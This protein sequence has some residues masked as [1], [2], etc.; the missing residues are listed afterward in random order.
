MLLSITLNDDTNDDKPE[1]Y[2]H[3]LPHRQNLL[4]KFIGFER[5]GAH[6]CDGTWRTQNM[7]PDVHEAQIHQN[8]S[9]PVPSIAA[10]SK[11]R[12]SNFC[13][14][15]DI[16][17]TSLRW[18]SRASEPLQPGGERSVRSRGSVHV[19]KERGRSKPLQV[20]DHQLL[21]AGV[22][23]LDGLAKLLQTLQGR[24][25]SASSLQQEEESEQLLLTFTVSWFMRR[26]CSSGLE[27][28]KE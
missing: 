8:L 23:G 2:A 12:G 21:D 14:H 10:E 25:N 6:G 9:E 19:K 3:N 28:R 7:T 11:P 20:T 15:R 4:Q 27:T 26:A 16:P 24:K 5:E 1:P 17:L 13:L 18:Y 22:R